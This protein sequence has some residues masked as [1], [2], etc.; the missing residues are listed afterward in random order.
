MSPSSRQFK[1][2]MYAQLARIGKALSAPVRLELLELL[3]QAP[4]TVETLARQAG[5]SVANASQHLRILHGARLVEASRR[6]LYV[7]YRI[8]NS[9]VLRFLHLTREFAESR[10]TDMSAIT[11][12]FLKSR[13]A[14][15]PVSGEKLIRRVR[16]GKVTVLDVRPAE[17]Y[18]AGHIPGALSVPL[19][20]LRKSIARLPK[21]REIVAYCRGPYCVMAIDA[22][23]ILRAAGYRAH[24]ME[25]GI[26]DWRVRGWRIESAL[27]PTRP[28][29]ARQ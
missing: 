19:G 15:E 25:H 22:V 24:R 9:Q 17:E 20:E 12:T 11:A 27:S 26:V 4:R 18:R 10:I 29:G 7:E 16:E 6:G 14:L 5:I 23:H 8:A 13:D 21:N 3:C 2:A 28:P 1:E